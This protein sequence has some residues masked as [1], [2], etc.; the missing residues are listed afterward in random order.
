MSMTAIRRA[1]E[2]RGHE[3][4]GTAQTHARRRRALD[5]FGELGLPGRRIEA[6]HYT[7]L[8]S[9]ADKAFDFIAPLPDDA[10]LDSAARLLAL[11]PPVDAGTRIVFVDGHRIESLGDAKAD[12]SIEILPLTLESAARADDSALSALNT[13]FLREGARVCVTGRALAPIELVFVGTGRGFAPQLKLAIELAAGAEATA[14]V[15][16]IDVPGADEGWLNLVTDLTLGEDSALTLYRLQTHD[17]QLN[18]TAI[19]RASLSRR[20]RLVAANVER[21]GKLVRNEFEIVLQGTEAEAHVFGLA[22]TRDRQHCDTRIA[23][24]HSA[25]RTTSRQDYRAIVADASRSVF[26]GKVV[27][28]QHAQHIDARQRNDNLLLSAKAEVDTKPELEIYA[29]QVIC[30][31]GATVGELDEEQLFYLR[32][33]GIDAES[34]RGILTTA[35]ADTILERIAHE[36]FRERARRAIDGALP[37][38]I[39][40][41]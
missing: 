6:W 12:P 18:H 2:D 29:D 41:G 3:L 39:G 1:F 40:I 17:A 20:A 36:G 28:R 19:H 35:F 23:I 8:S 21:G 9:F 14:I 25:A 7:D 37:R 30:S 32:T 5:R 38:A 24:D 31:H 11:H 27:V 33:R 15:S 13:A 10:A 22:L 16:F 4:P 26:N 34:A